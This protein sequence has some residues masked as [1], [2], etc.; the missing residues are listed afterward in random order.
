MMP[1][2]NKERAERR[3]R[4][5][6]DY[7]GKGYSANRIQRELQIQDVG[8]QRKRL[9]LIVRQYRRTKPKPS[10]KH[11][12]IKYRGRA[13]PWGAYYYPAQKQ[14]AIYGTYMGQSRRIV[15][16]GTGRE[17]YRIAGDILTH[18][19]EIRFLRISAYELERHPYRYLK[20]RAW[21]DERPKIES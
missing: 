8:M 7:V 14:I 12:P 18:P 9:L 19:P 3:D 16:T 15:V 21:W 10:E 4:L 17:L 20:W 13:S 1:R 5:I 6:K 2:M 11:I